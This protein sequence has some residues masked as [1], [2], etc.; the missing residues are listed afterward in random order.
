[1]GFLSQIFQRIL[2]SSPSLD[3]SD[4]GSHTQ[5][6]KKAWIVS[7]GQGYNGRFSPIPIILLII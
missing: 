5:S 3:A 2:G 7:P 4:G 1:V 6:K